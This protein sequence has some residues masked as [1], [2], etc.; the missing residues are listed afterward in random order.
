MVAL[1][2]APSEIEVLW[3]SRIAEAARRF[4][5]HRIKRLIIVDADGQLARLVDRRAVFQSLVDATE[6]GSDRTSP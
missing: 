1:P 4:L 3:R 5:A 2:I 6:A